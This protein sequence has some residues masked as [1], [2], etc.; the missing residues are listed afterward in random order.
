MDLDE[1]F[2]NSFEKKVIDTNLVSQRVKECRNLVIDKFNDIEFIEEGHI[3]KIDG[4]EYTSVS[5]I[6]K[7]YEPEVDW[8][9]KAADY[10]RKW[11]KKKEDV[12][13]EW[14]LNNLKSTISGTR[15]H[16]FGESVVNLYCG[17]PELICEQNKP[18]YIKEYNVLIPTYP[19]EEAVVHFF[20]ELEDNLHPVGAEFKLSSKYIENTLPICGTCDILFYNSN[21]D[22]FVLGDWK[23]NKSL[24][25]DYSRYHKIMM[26]GCVSDMINE[27]ISEYT[28]QFNLY[29]K[30]LE[31]IGI[32][33]SDRI[34][35]WLKDDGTYER[36]HI[37]KM[38]DSV[39][40]KIMRGLK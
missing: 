28:I 37:D 21:D 9:Q 40:N 36:I 3:Y 22:T 18:Q 24:I 32:N 29:Q 30:M 25:K 14:K 6:I 11:G 17:Y 20:D 19:K 38:S 5:N 31:S 16:S 13:K 8:D 27:P 7:K 26:T 1:I 39:I 35:I 23:T 10:A 33:I 34:L 4:T 2:D 12:Q 15:T